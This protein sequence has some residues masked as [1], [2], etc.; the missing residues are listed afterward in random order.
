M[1][2]PCAQTGFFFSLRLALFFFLLLPKAPSTQL[3]ILVV[4]ASGCGMLPQHGLMSGTTSAPRIRTSE[5]PGHRIG[6]CK[7]NNLAMGPT[8]RTGPVFSQDL[9]QLPRV[10]TLHGLSPWAARPASFWAQSPWISGSPGPSQAHLVCLSW[11]LVEP[12][13]GVSSP[14]YPPRILPSAP[15]GSGHP[16]GRVALRGE[17]RTRGGTRRRPT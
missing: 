3:Y 5:T 2:V 4:S 14:L 10:L 13:A 6:A 11:T 17:H 1:C 15:V 12:W 9:S 7:L 8:P 16:R